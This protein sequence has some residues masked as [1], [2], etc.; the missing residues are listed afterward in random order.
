MPYY[1]DDGTPIP[2]V[3]EVVGAGDCEA[4]A[5]QTKNQKDHYIQTSHVVVLPGTL[6]HGKIENDQ[7]KRIGLPPKPF[8]EFL[9]EP[10]SP[11]REM[12]KKV[13]QLH[14]EQRRKNPNA[15]TSYITLRKKAKQC[16]ENYRSFLNDHA[17]MMPIRNWI[18]GRVRSHLF[19][20]AGTVD[21]IAT[22]TLKGRLV[23]RRVLTEAQIK[24]F[25]LKLPEKE[26]F[27]ECIEENCPTFE[28]VVPEGRKRAVK[29]P[30]PKC[31]CKY[32][33]TITVRNG[34][35]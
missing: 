11:D 28:M 24:Q 18:E 23:K 9:G 32:I 16:F 22:I 26:Y 7:R 21:L 12:W 4:E 15:I 14:I 34:C 8:D 17:D 35:P 3:T 33:E 2:R 20:Y 13:H 19:N 31:N 6:T 29:T 30:L 1:E 5:H 25:D 10:G 27:L